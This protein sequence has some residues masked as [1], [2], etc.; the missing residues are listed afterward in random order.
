MSNQAV[1]LST[2]Q[3][4]H[5]FDPAQFDFKS[6]DELPPYEGIIGQE[7]ALRAISFG[8]NI[9]SQGYHLYALGPVG[10]GKK[11]IISKYLETH[12]KTK[13]VP[14]DWLYVNNFNDSDTPRMLRLP[15]GKGREFRDDLDQL[16]EE[17]KTEVPKAFES[18]E[19]QKER[20]DN[21]DLYNKKSQELFLKLEEK[22]KKAGFRL[23]QGP[24]GIGIVAVI[25]GEALTAEKMEKL[26]DDTLKKIGKGQKELE[27]EIRQT[28]RQ[29]QEIQKEAKQ[30]ML[31]IDRKT[32]AFAID[33][34]L[35]ELKEKY[36]E[37]ENVIAFL[38]EVRA[39]LLKHVT[40]FKQLKKMAE[41]SP[42]QR[43]FL[44]MMQEQ[45]V[46]F[47]E[48]RANLIVDNSSTS[49]APVVYEKN[50]TAANLLGRVEYVGRFGALVTNFR[51]IKNG[52]L[53]KAN[54]GYLI[55]DAF[56]LLTK[57]LAW[58]TLKRALKNEEVVIESLE[59]TLGF[60][61]TR[62]L[63]P[64][65]IPLD[66][67]VIIIGDPLL[68]Y[69]LYSLDQDFPE[70]FKVKADFDF[71]TPWTEESGRMY[72]HFIGN[73]CREEGLKHF[74]PD[75]VSRVIEYSARLAAHQKKLITVFGDVVDIIR[76]ASFWAEQDGKKLVAET[77]V[78]KAIDEKIY[79]SNRIE[80][81]I[82]E[83]IEE[84]TI[85]IDTTG[86][87]VGQ[88]NGISVLPLGDYSFGKPSRITARAFVGS[89]GILNIDRETELGGPI[90]NKGSLILAGYLGGRYA[91]DIP[92]ALSASITFEQLYEG[93]EGDS[94]SSS[95]LYALLSSLSGFPV[96]QDL[97]VTGSVNQ[98]GEVQAIGGAN[99]K[100]EGFFAVCQAKGLTG[101][102]GVIIPASNIKHL[103]LRDEVVEAVRDGKFHIYAVSTID[104]GIA[105]LTGRE[106]GEKTE[107][108]FY[109]EGTVNWAVQQKI[110]EL[111][112][113][114][115]AFSSSGEEDEDKDAN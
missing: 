59:K 57:P 75:G 36:R 111:A 21:K 108:G 17:L 30:K 93:V 15:A 95:E 28:M 31:E 41:A 18:N 43:Q 51:M 73:I 84:E 69:L 32:V 64:E 80:K 55:L 112:A 96:R 86:E 61:T 90:H 76:Q 79:R 19:Y 8:I 23:L 94:A 91:E 34:F 87:K 109:A 103:M 14:D 42:E 4:R 107:E 10:T 20:Q 83:M 70:L 104:E 100:I 65:P 88:V 48:Y 68:Y 25:E 56:D 37:F 66:I 81:I 6:T 22:V 35:D 33:H 71:R 46:T 53:H 24:D 82:Q 58:E 40:S 115:R 13:P 54:G 11:T 106:A 97:A 26:D 67:K 38:V 50:P 78:R 110:W 77:E 102:Q 74:S 2:E 3:L 9:K 101:T 113:K 63:E 12:A 60:M 62:T 105:L 5:R 99:E 52:A 39:F 45:Q 85:L 27:D 114:V 7:R 16:V 49:G 47:D 44:A 29:A 98:R 1:K 72:A 92:L 89:K